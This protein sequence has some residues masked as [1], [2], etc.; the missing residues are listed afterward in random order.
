M[1]SYRCVPSYLIAV[2]SF[3]RLTCKV[4]GSRHPIGIQTFHVLRCH[5][6]KRHVLGPFLR[7]FRSFYSLGRHGF[8]CLGFITLILDPS[9]SVLGYIRVSTLRHGFSHVWLGCSYHSHCHLHEVHWCFI[10]SGN[11]LFTKRQAHFCNLLRLDHCLCRPGICSTDNDEL[12]LPVRL[13]DEPV[14]DWIIILNIASHGQLER[15]P[16]RFI[17][18][19]ERN[20]VESTSSAGVGSRS[21]NLH[22]AVAQHLVVSACHCRCCHDLGC[23]CLTQYISCTRQGAR[24]SCKGYCRLGSM[25]CHHTGQEQVPSVG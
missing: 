21:Q 10:P 4:A 15:S 2:D 7:L 25:S 13:P 20:V 18:P 5:Y 23:L 6:S 9:Q 22:L 11:H 3:S 19:Q 12:L 14:E 17:A 16:Q 8:S 24:V 1:S